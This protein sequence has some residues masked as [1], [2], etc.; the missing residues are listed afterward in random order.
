[1]DAVQIAARH[2]Q[3][4]RLL[5][6][7]SQQNR[8]KVF[9]QLGCGH[10]FLGPVGHFGILGPL[11]HQHAGAHR[12]AFGLQLR[13]APVDV[14]F[15]HFEIGDAVAQQAAN[16]VILFKHR[17]RMADTRQLLRRGQTGGAG[18]NNGYFFAGLL[19][20][21]LGVY[22]AFGPGAVDDGV[23]NGLD[24]HRVVIDV[25]RTRCF[26]GR[27]ANAA[28][29]LGEII[30]AVQDLNRSF[31]I[32]LEHQVVEVR[33]DVVDRAAAVA[34]RRAAVHAARALGFGLLVVQPDHK[35]FVIFDAL[36]NRGIALFDARKLHESGNFSH[37]AG[38]VLSV[39]RAYTAALLLVLAAAG[40][41]AA[42]VFLV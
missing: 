15:V 7:T 10:G 29:E 4:A 34:K 3:V 41:L 37:D 8:V 26:A 36:G 24:A 38:P 1:M 28:G 6:T 9:L 2:R 14:A 5:G 11:A 35:L 20:C 25:Q 39:M 32:I 22:P 19:C 42:A 21:R 18:A 17:H 40:G 12:H 13:H 23:L 27:G 16:A 33:D 30:R 31:P